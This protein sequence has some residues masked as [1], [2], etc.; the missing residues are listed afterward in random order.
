[1]DN[2]NIDLKKRLSNIEKHLYHLYEILVK[3][4][5]DEA[6]KVSEGYLNI[7]QATELLGISKVTLYRRTSKRTIPFYKKGKKVYFKRTELEAWMEK[8]RRKS[9]GELQEEA[10]KSL[11]LRSRNC[12]SEKIH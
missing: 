4:T 5:P 11:R 9:D 2:D 7:E 10:H 12:P 3:K 1:M 8:G 6:R